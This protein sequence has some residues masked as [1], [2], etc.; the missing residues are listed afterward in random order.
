MANVPSKAATPANGTTAKKV[1]R[2]YDAGEAS[3]KVR[4]MADRARKAAKK[5]TAGD[6]REAMYTSAIKSL[7]LA[8]RALEDASLA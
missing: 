5:L 8:A 7:T 2:P 6:P 1:A 4:K 3:N